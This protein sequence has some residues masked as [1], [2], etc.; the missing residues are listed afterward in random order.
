MRIKWAVLW[1]PSDFMKVAKIACIGTEVY[2]ETKTFVAA[3]IASV[4]S[5]AV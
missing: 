5:Y 4:C 3:I 1:L 2:C